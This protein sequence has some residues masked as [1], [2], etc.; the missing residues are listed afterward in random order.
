MSS[1]LSVALALR[2]SRCYGYG[3]AT[4]SAKH[5]DINRR[6]VIPLMPRDRSKI[7]R[8]PSLPKGIGKQHNTSR[9]LAPSSG[10][11]ERIYWPFINRFPRWLPASTTNISPVTLEALVRKNSAAS[12][13]CSGVLAWRNGVVC[14]SALFSFSYSA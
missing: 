10:A 7:V 12:A 3:S 2:A 8:I 4:A 11:S 1:R 14:L 9:V 13:I 5:C 6:T